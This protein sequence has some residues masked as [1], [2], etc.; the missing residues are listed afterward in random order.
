VVEEVPIELHPL[1]VRN[2]VILEDSSKEILATPTLLSEFHA[3]VAGPSSSAPP[4]LV[5]QV[6]APGGDDLDDSGDDE[7]EEEEENNDNIVDANNEQEDNFVGLWPVAEHYTSMFETG[8]FPNLLH[9]VLHALGTYIRPLYYTRR[10]SEPPRAC[11]YIT[12]VH[13]RVLDAGDRGF[14]TLSSHE[15]LTPLSTYTA[16]VSNAARRAL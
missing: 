5:A 11:Y 14:R 1:Q 2:D 8:H 3:F 9:D 15:S 4:V 10:V 6:P 16:S 12:R 7:D 13:S